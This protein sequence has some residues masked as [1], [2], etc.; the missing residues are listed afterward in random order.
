MGCR[1]S[2]GPSW[3][4]QA[5]GE[6]EPETG[7]CRAGSSPSAKGGQEALRPGGDES[8][9]LGVRYRGPGARGWE[10]EGR[11]CMRQTLPHQ[12]QILLRLE[13]GLIILLLGQP[14]KN[15]SPREPSVA[16]SAQKRGSC[17]LGKRVTASGQ[18]TQQDM[19]TRIFTWAF[20]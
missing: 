7:R 4:V 14:Q 12:A 20:L 2:G 16:L 10:C 1:N 6:S 11:G 8:T 19:W 3:G 15:L 13:L 17:K 5:D 18:V 9:S